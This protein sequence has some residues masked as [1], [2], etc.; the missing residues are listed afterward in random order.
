MDKYFEKHEDL[1]LGKNQR[2]ETVFHVACKHGNLDVIKKSYE[3]SVS[4]KL[5][6]GNILYNKNRDGYTCF[7]LACLNGFIVI[8]EYFLRNLKMKMFLEI[9]D[10]KWNTPLHLATANS[11]LI[12]FMFSNLIKTNFNFC[13]F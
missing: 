3:K 5:Y 6:S 13:L 8:C 2:D 7:H 11:F 9:Q 12:V 1:V 4:S 10:N